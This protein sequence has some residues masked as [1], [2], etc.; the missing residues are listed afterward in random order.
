MVEVDKYF[1]TSRTGGGSRP[2]P[3]A[4]EAAANRRRI[5]GAIAARATG[6]SRP[7]RPSR[8]G[9]PEPAKPP[10]RNHPRVS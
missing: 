3:G 9:V 2:E 6:R 10:I 8:R 5:D 1:R 7:S 4:E